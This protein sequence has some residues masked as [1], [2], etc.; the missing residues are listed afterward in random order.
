MEKLL[1]YG[2][3]TL[4]IIKIFKTKLTSQDEEVIGNLV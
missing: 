4:R 1:I 2:E 3:L